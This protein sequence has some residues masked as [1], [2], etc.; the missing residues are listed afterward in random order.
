MGKMTFFELYKIWSKKSFIISV[1]VILIINV[2]LLWYTNL[3]DGTEPELYSYKLFQEDIRDMTDQEKYDY[4][5]KLYDDIQGINFVNE[6]LNYRALSNEMGEQLAEQ[7]MA[8]NPDL[9]EKYYKSFQNENYLKYTKSKEQEE[10]FI[11]EIYDEMVKVSGYKEYLSKVQENK[12]N[13]SSISIFT[14]NSQKNTFSS[15]NIQKSAADYKKLDDVKISFYPSKGIVSAMKNN[16]SDVLL[17]L[18]VFLFVGILMYEEK[19]KRLFYITRATRKGREHSIVAKLMATLMNCIIV[20]VLMYGANIL[21]FSETTGMGEWFRSIQSVAPFMESNLHINILE[22]SLLS[23]FTK[24][25]VL[26][27]VGAFIMF[28]S[29]V[30]KQSFMPFLIG[31][32]SIGFGALLYHMIPAYGTLNSLKYLNIIGLLKTENIY[33][34]YLNFNFFGY[35]ES[36][37]IFSIGSAILH[38]GIG[39]ALSFVAFLRCINLENKKIKFLFRVQ[40]KPHT[41][42]FRYEGYKILIMNKALI[43]LLIFSTLLG[44]RN[45][46]AQYV[47]TP[48][49]EYYKSI[50]IQLEGELTDKKESIIETEKERYEKAFD[51]IEE[52][53]ELAALGS[54]DEKVADSMKEP[55]YGEIMF[56]PAFQKVLKQYDFVK[57]TKGKFIYDTG[58]LY[59]FG[60][61]DT[62]LLIDLLLLSICIILAFGNV[63]TMEQR[64][65][66]NL[67]SATSMGKKKIVCRK[68]MVCAIA[69]VIVS[70]IPF[71]CKVINI[72]HN[73]PLHGFLTSL[74]SIPEYMGTKINIPIIGWIL[75]MIF[76]Q[77]SVTM[78][79]MAIVFLFSKYMKTQLQTIFV[80]ILILVI[81]LILKEMGFDFA[82]QCSLLPFYTMFQ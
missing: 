17:I 34:G 67:L 10:K 1:V 58:Y 59:L 3:S 80:A 57:K 54:I 21:F 8:S 27:G 79:I 24:A 6:I 62:G 16:I 51:K 41:N 49:E 28:V 75:I 78:M 18:S 55:Y 30:S 81:P 40:W 52:I 19:E 70:F 64:K 13:L 33:A 47:L 26:F 44:Y 42:L 61:K 66:W 14:N 22:Y 73:Y 2:F 48:K 71:I 29:I 38:G 23:I 9:F 74:K 5:K 45:L 11:N 65:S 39:V 56:Y 7:K 4:V 12:S 20:T 53:D 82:G 69:T 36:R 63:M 35:P 72:I 37:M 60:I 31:G 76:V 46:S 50:M 43:I 15:R 25:M 32:V 77:M 68:I